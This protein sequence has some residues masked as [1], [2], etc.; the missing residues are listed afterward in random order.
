[1]PASIETLDT[2]GFQIKPVVE[3]DPWNDKS[4]FSL[5]LVPR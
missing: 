3:Y 4:V 2:G 5:R 1:M